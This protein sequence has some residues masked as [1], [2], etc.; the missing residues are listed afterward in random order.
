MKIL[1][2]NHS[3]DIPYPV[4][5][6]MSITKEIVSEM[7][8]ELRKIY[9]NKSE[10][11]MFL[12][13]G[14]SGAILAGII[15][16]MMSEYDDIEIMHIKKHGESSHSGNYYGL[17]NRPCKT[18]ILDDFIESGKTVNSIYT[19]VAEDNKNL[20][21]DTLCVSGSVFIEKLCFKPNNLICS[22]YESNHE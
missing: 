21:I 4:G 13:R 6:A 10:P 11:L 18:I 17:W 7:A 8:S 3:S 15:I 9:P 20:T 16:S 2:L 1:K 5:K 14:S 22:R 19:S 12:V